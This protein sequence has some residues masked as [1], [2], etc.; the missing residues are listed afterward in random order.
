MNGLS[1]IQN[2]IIIGPAEIKNNIADTVVIK[3]YFL[4]P[5][6]LESSEINDSSI[7]EAKENVQILSIR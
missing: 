5:I 1:T 2:L 6:L 7:H 3:K 4:N